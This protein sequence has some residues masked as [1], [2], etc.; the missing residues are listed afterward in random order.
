MACN[1]AT[2][3]PSLIGIVLDRIDRFRPSAALRHFAVLL[4]VL[5]CTVPADA[6][7]GSEPAANNKPAPVSPLYETLQGK[8]EPVGPDTYMLPDSQ[9]NLQPVLNMSIEQLMQAMRLRQAVTAATANSLKKYTLDEC[10]FIGLL[11]GSHASISATFQIT[12]HTSDTVE[13]PLG[14]AGS[15]LRKP[16][17]P[18]KP[19]DDGRYLRY[20][21]S[22]GGFLVTLSGEPGER[23]QVLLELL[24]PV[25]WDGSRGAIDLLAPRATSRGSLVLV[26]KNSIKSVAASEGVELSTS[27]LA[28]G[29]MRVKAEG[30]VGEFTLSW[31][32]RDDSQQPTSVLSA[33][34]QVLVS[35]D[36]RDVKCSARITVDAF[37]RSFREFTVR[38]PPGAS[39]VPSASH[40]QNGQSASPIDTV[41]TAVDSNSAGE[42]ASGQGNRGTE[43]RVTLSSDQTEPVTLEVQTIEPL[44]GTGSGIDFTLSGFEVI[45]AVPQVGEVGILVDDAWQLQWE[46]NDSVRPVHSSEVDFSWAANQL[47][48]NKLTTVLRFARQPWSLPV[49]LAPREERVVATP[50]YKIR[51][52]PDEALLE[53]EVAYRLTGGRALPILFSPRFSLAGWDHQKTTTRNIE[54]AIE[55]EEQQDIYAFATADATSRSP[56]V[57][58][59]LR[60]PLEV[61]A[62]GNFVLTLPEPQGDALVLN[63]GRVTVIAD[64][65]LQLTPDTSLSIGLVPLPV[66]EYT[67]EEDGVATGQQYR[68]RGVYQP[69]V[70]AGKQKPRPQ[71]LLVDSRSSVEMA[72]DQVLVTQDLEFEVRHQPVTSLTL[73]LP[74]KREAIEQLELLPPKGTSED[75]PGIPLEISGPLAE[76]V[77]ITPML[78]DQT[79]DLSHPRMGKF[80]IRAK[81]LLDPPDPKRD[82]YVLRLLTVPDAEFG[83]H[84]LHLRPT[85][86][87]ALAHASKLRWRAPESGARLSSTDEAIYTTSRQTSYL[88][89]T[90]GGSSPTIDTLDIERVWVQS[91]ITWRAMQTRAVFGFRGGGPQ[92]RIELPK[93]APEGESF[94]VIV[95]GT[96]SGAWRRVPGALFVELPTSQAGDK[97]TLEL[98]YR[99]PIY[100]GWAIS[101]ASGRPRMAGDDTLAH[102][103]WQVITPVEY[104][105]VA[106]SDSLVV[107]SHTAWL[108]GD[109]RSSSELDTADL[110]RWIG[111]SSNPVRPTRGEHSFL[112]RGAPAASLQIN[113]VR[114]ELL[115]LATSGVVLAICIALAYVPWLR[116]TPVLLAGLAIVATAGLAAPQ[117]TATIAPLGLYGLVCGLLV[118]ALSV[119]Y[120]P[121]SPVISTAHEP[122]S[123]RAMPLGTQPASSIVPLGS[124][125]ISSNAPTVAVEMA[126]SNV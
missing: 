88:T 49:R 48:D 85:G 67:E 36:G 96:V 66:D 7:D 99:T 39:H 23:V 103:R 86:G 74:V 21:P 40:T 110:E 73:A 68:Y 59:D 100:A 25:R 75:S 111:V 118:W 123:H 58:L 105:R 22:D 45:G 24:V 115:I 126:D 18:P 69:L 113:L 54:R 107:E 51:L 121:R 124:G 70:F 106:E 55:V 71:R 114:R 76:E 16:P 120:G 102:L 11:E 13:I 3:P 61:D 65:S 35:M 95:D 9:G 41:E 17:T 8:I 117:L 116:Q 4:V 91:W 50:S 32:D 84:T 33:S 98:R 81:Y 57:T 20:D 64:T 31:V 62:D 79:I 90:S 94:E 34:S 14:M 28:A 104:H 63:G 5:V 47:T 93:D 12:L 1:L 43:L 78:P 27:P 108:D 80:R 52:S 56:T 125:A 2:P 60:R 10:R 77:A 53:M 26:S 82:T 109:W 15:K 112:F 30:V 6:Q 101:L 72:D 29:G 87:M 119:M 92:V 83:T 42:E 37:G 46:P 122:D 19:R 97:H 38:L 44:H 89:L